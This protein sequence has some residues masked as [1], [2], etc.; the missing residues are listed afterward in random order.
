MCWA[1]TMRSYILFPFLVVKAGSCPAK[2]FTCVAFS[3]PLFHGCPSGLPCRAKQH[4]WLFF[5]V[6]FSKKTLNCFR[7]PLPP[8]FQQPPCCWC[9]DLPAQQCGSIRGSLH[10][11]LR[12]PDFA[13]GS[14]DLEKSSTIAW[15]EAFYAHFWQ[16]H[17]MYWLSSPH[18]LLL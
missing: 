1:R 13:P 7:L 17:L 8:P 16:I 12:D 5:K 11:A 4:F 2:Q 9:F 6:W 18:I 14:N 10:C 3:M 15:S